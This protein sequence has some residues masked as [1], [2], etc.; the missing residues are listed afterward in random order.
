MANTDVRFT[1]LDLIDIDLKEHNSLNLHCIGGRKGLNKQINSPDL[2]RPMGAIM[3]FYEDF[4]SHRI[5]VF[6]R[7]EVSYLRRLENSGELQ[8]IRDLFG[9]QIPC[10][11]FTHNLRPHD[12]FLEIAESAQCPL[13]QTDLGT[14]DFTVRLMRILAEIFAPRKSLHGVLVEVFGLGILILGDSGIGKS[15]TTLELIHRGHRLVADDVVEIRCVNGN[16]LMGAGA[17][18]IIGH[19]MEIRGL[20]IIN[21]TY[22]FGVRAIRNRKEIQLVVTL[23]TWDSAKAYDRLGI[24]EQTMDILGVAIPKLEIPVKLGRNIPII[25]ETAAMNERLKSMGYNAA[26]EFNKNI[27]KWLESDNARSP[28]LGHDDVI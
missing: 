1:V 4:A 28:F 27:L 26:K 8:T 17:N 9:Y 25:I 24:D 13:L 12:A 20:G 15:E 16:M 18:K 6:G 10:C 11:I 22:M 19:H 5:Q 2:N 3:G 21:I 7:G 23:D 14:A